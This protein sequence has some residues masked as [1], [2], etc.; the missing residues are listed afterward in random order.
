MTVELLDEA[1]EEFLIT[2]ANIWARRLTT[3]H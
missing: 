3:T 1:E 2:V